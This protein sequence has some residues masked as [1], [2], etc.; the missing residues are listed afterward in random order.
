MVR[1][2]LHA[3]HGW[4]PVLLTLLLWPIP[5]AGQKTVAEVIP[6]TELEQVLAAH[7]PSWKLVRCG[8]FEGGLSLYT[9]DYLVRSSDS[10]PHP[11][12]EVPCRLN[13]DFDGDGVLD[14]AAQLHR[15]NESLR[16]QIVVV[17]FRRQDGLHPVYAGE[18]ADTLGVAARGTVA[19]DYVTQRSIRYENDAISVGRDEATGVTLVFRD[20]R[21]LL[22]H[23]A[24]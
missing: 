18:G 6:E 11:W 4:L 16:R 23:T 13:G 8:K 21:F 15:A 14:A 3:L 5:A 12:R 17:V 10:S 2:S 9:V 20:G 19:H 7:F 24:D 1:E 22:F